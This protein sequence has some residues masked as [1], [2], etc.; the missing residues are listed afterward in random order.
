MRSG[1]VL[2]VVTRVM[3]LTRGKLMKQPNWDEWQASKYLQL[4]QYDAQG[5]FG[6][7]DGGYVSVP[8]GVD[9]RH[10]GLGRAKESTVGM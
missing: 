8:F 3:R 7:L 10:E 9:V 5:M 2:N 6:P 4:D 1:D